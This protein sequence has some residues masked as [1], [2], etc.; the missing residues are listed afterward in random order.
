MPVYNCEDYIVDSITSILNQTYN[1]F[2]FIIVN[3]ASTDR[4]LEKINS[5]N[6]S[7]IKVV[8]NETNL[9]IANSLNKAIQLSKGKYIARMDGD[10]ICCT[11]RIETQIRYLEENPEIDILG[12]NIFLIDRKNRPQGKLPEPPRHSIN[13]KI[14]LSRQ[15][16]LAHPTTVFRKE[17]IG[18]NLKYSNDFP[19]AEDYEL[20]LRL[21]SIGY[22]SANLKNYLLHYRI[23]PNSLSRANYH[24]AND[25][26]MKAIERHDP[27]NLK[28]TINSDVYKLI[29]KPQL[30]KTDEDLYITLTTWN[31]AKAEHFSRF[32][33]SKEELGEL[34]FFEKIFIIQLI[35][36]Q[37]I[38]RRKIPLKLLKL[39]LVN[40]LNAP[41][42]TSIRLGRNVYN[43]FFS[44]HINYKFIKVKSDLSRHMLRHSKFE[45]Q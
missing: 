13:H 26:M 15:N 14:L 42:S 43:Y 44:K 31:K 32:T 25:S 45:N 1:N 21:N 37:L 27:L 5:F 39:L 8:N 11:E 30:I 16:T 3:D 2:E 35:F 34:H 23:H 20:W 40:Q 6:D 41:I 24:Q 38:N 19:H 18:E 17:R 9:K 7:R 33:Y 29:R 36:F 10:D 12:S 4:T 28:T 22:K